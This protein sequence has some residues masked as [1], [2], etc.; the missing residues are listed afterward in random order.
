M[1][2]EH[3]EGHKGIRLLRV[4]NV[5]RRTGIPERTVRHL[6]ATGRLQGVRLGLKIWAF[7]PA[8]VDAFLRRRRIHAGI[9]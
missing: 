4:N 9:W 5:A 3:P 8:A 7:E 6:A 2:P 1:N